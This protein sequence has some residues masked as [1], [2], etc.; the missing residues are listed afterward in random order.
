MTDIEVALPFWLDRPDHEATDVALAAADTGFAALWIGEM[1]TYDAF[2]LATSIGLRT[3]NMTLKVGPLAVGVRGPVGLALGVSSVASLTGCRVDLAL[4]AS[5]PA[6]VAGWHG[7]PWAHHVPVMRETIECLRSIFTGARV[8]YSGRHVNSRGFR[9]RGAAPDTRIA[10]G[11]FG[12]GMIRLAAQHADEVVLNLASPFRVGR[13]RAAIDSA[14][15][16][17]GRAAPRRASRCGCRSPSTP[18]RPRTPSWQLSWR[19]TSPRPAMAKC[20]ARWVSTA[21]SVA[22]GP[23]LLAANWR[24]LSPANC[25]TGCVRWVAPIEWR[26]GSAPTRMPVPIASRSCPPPLKTRGAGWLCERCDPAGSTAPLATTTADGNLDRDG[27]VAMS[28]GLFGLLD[29]VAVLARLAAASI[30]DIGAAA[31][32]ATAKAAGVVIDDTA[33]TPQ[34]VHRITAEREL[35]IIKRIAIGSV[36]NKLLLILPGALLLSQLVPWLLTPLLMLGATYLCYEGAEK[37]CGV[38]GGRGHDAAP[39]VAER[40]LVAGAIR[41]DFILSAEIM[42][43]ALNEV[44]DQPFVPRLIVLVIVALVI[45]A[46]VYGVVAVI[47]QMDDVGLRLTQTASRFGQRIGGGLVAGMPK[48]L[49]ALSAVGMGATL[50]VGGHIVLVGSDHL[51]WHAPYRLVHHLDDHLVGSAGGALTWLV[52]TAA[53]AATGLVIGIVVVALVHLVCFRPPRS[54]SL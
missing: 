5:S 9:L 23:G 36:R 37:V 12:P 40:E 13:V 20:S 18:V 2:A 8:E 52:S 30:D 38:I 3:P 26:P 28:G 19:C 41:T 11:A 4:G 27:G 17:A 31:G 21:W 50:W 1:A 16:A 29:H 34:Y 25:S 10:L 53:C 47:V 39:Q 32:R 44:A 43:I 46:A 33:V 7:R 49:S 6:I 35:P 24:S 15:A 45:T 42:V 48:L 54:R 14:A 22:R 51:G